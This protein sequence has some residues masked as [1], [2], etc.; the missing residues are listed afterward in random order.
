[1]RAATK[2]SPSAAVNDQSILVLIAGPVN[3]PDAVAARITFGR[4]DHPSLGVINVAAD[5]RKVPRTPKIPDDTDPVTRSLAELQLRDQGKR[6]E[7]MQ[8]LTRQGVDAKRQ[9][10]VARALDAQLQERDGFTRNEAIKTLAVWG[11]SESVPALIAL[12]GHD[13]GGTRHEAIKTLASLCDE[14]AIEPITRRFVEDRGE[15]MEALQIFG[16]KAEPAVIQLL[17]HPDG[18]VRTDA[19]K[20]LKIIGTKVSLPALRKVVRAGGFPEG[21]AREAIQAIGSD[22]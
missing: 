10:E 19:C 7:A 8:R 17:Q 13:D 6:R 22:H 14:R 4:V 3:D 20:V 18:F 11:D 2:P 9:A 5:M 1:M 15:A 21:A 16:E 12:L